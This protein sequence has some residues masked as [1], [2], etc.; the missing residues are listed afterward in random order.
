MKIE[1][2]IKNTYGNELIYP[3]CETAK[4]LVELAG[5][6][7]FTDNSIRLCKALGYE[8]SIVAAQ[9]SL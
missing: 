2:I 6:K 7:T 1:V 9:R 4:K 8:L 3:V 5:A